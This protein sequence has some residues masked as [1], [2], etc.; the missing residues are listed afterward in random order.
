MNELQHIPLDE[1]LLMS[2]KASDDGDTGLANK[3]YQSFEN[4]RE[5]ALKIA[6]KAVAAG[7]TKTVDIIIKSFEKAKTVSTERASYESLNHL[8][9]EIKDGL[10]NKSTIEQQKINDLAKNMISQFQKINQNEIF[11]DEPIKE[12][13][14]KQININV[15]GNSFKKSA[16]KTDE[17]LKKYLK[18]EKFEIAE[19]RARKLLEKKPKSAYLHN[20]I[21][22]C[23]AQQKLF[24]EALK[25][26][27]TSLSIEPDAQDAI[28][29]KSII[30]L[31]NGNFKKGW[32]LYEAGL[33]DNIREVFENYF[34]E[35][36]PVWD[37][38]PFEGT[39]LIYGEQGIGD[40][41]MFGTL[42][43]DLLKIQNNLAVV[44]DKR[45]KEIFE[46][47]YPEIKFFGIQESID[48][49]YDKHI[50]IG[51]LCKFLRTDISQ[52]KKGE[53]KNYLISPDI[54]RQTKTLFP[55]TKGL[56][57]GI[58]WHSF[59]NKNASRRS[60]SVNEVSNIITASDNTFINLQYGD[61]EK[62]LDQIE[63]LSN[64][65]INAISGINLTENLHGLAS[66]INNCDL[67]ITI[68]N[69]TAHL[70]ASL[71]KPVWILLPYFNDFRWMEESDL[72]I[73]YEN[74]FLLRQTNHKDWS[75]V[76]D[77]IT[78]ALNTE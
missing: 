32:D 26:L 14:K 21:A 28:F 5:T 8:N 71:G 18:E 43:E 69:S 25:S 24:D 33:G 74:V 20:Y 62:Q 60:L 37:G 48:I 77:N 54:N 55:S 65:N 63:Q 29:N 34:L 11:T 73:W 10:E 70:A 15:K 40:Q 19:K 64:K 56:K 61:I 67:I 78:T 42:F 9:N 38:K 3:F 68:D 45:L 39:L 36:T 76:I 59:A 31:R 58:S 66:I 4:A 23:Q 51:S 49:T 30:N 46:R 72:S 44:I 17:L 1:M 2:F 50:A 13:N 27:E 6:E 52:F 41:I 12:D 57:I 35:T 47:T 75:S 7:D 16:T 22:V 53:F